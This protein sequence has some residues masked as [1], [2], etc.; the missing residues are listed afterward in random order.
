M[1]TNEKK[2]PKSDG[3][4]KAGVK[5]Y[6]QMASIKSY[7]SATIISDPQIGT[8]QVSM[9][10][11][12][13]D[14]DRKCKRKM[15]SNLTVQVIQESS[16]QSGLTDFKVIARHLPTDLGD[17]E[18]VSVSPS[19]KVQLTSR[20]VDKKRF[21]EITT[22]GS[23]RTIEVTKKHGDFFADGTFG[24]VSWSADETKFVYVSDRETPDNDSKYVESM[25]L[26]EGFTGKLKPTLVFVD[27]AGDEPKVTPLCLDLQASQA[28]MLPA[29]DKIIFNGIE[30][31][32]LPF[33]ILYCYNRRTAIY[34]VSV[35]GTG[36]ERLSA[37]SGVNGRYPQ[38][39]PDGS[40]FVYLSHKVGGA[41]SACNTLV[42][43]KLKSKESSTLVQLVKAVCK[44]TE[45]PGLF[46]DHLIERPWVNIASGLFAILQTSWRCQETLVAVNAST[47]QVHR[48]T[49]LLP[50][51][52]YS[53]V[54]RS[55]TIDGWILATRSLANEPHKLVLGKFE[56]PGKTIN[57]TIIDEPDLPTDVSEG[58]KNI[59][60]TVSTVPGCGPNVQVLM[61]MP[62]KARHPQ[63][64]DTDGG[65]PLVVMPHGGPHGVISTGYSLY[66]SLLVSFGFAV[67]Q[68]NYS[69]STG[70]GDDFVQDVVGRIG[71][72]DLADVN[73]AAYWAS[74]LPGI[75][76]KK[77]SLFGG[78]HG[79]FITAHLLG[80]E[81]DFYKAGVLRNP[82]IN[83]GAMVATT[84]ISDWCF[85]EAGLAFDQSKPHLVTPQEYEFMFRHSPASVVHKIKSPVLLML[86]AGDRRVPP[87][88][89][90]RWSQ[91]LRGAGKDISV[92]MFPSVGHALDSFEAER[93]GFDAYWSF[94][95]KH[96]GQPAKP[97]DA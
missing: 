92:I 62:T 49:S 18:I 37:E 73:A 42:L 66:L 39:T 76:K 35:D 40:A 17:T 83:I 13:R 26:G 47:G 21:L 60:L 97:I 61:L 38:L 82:V 28:I 10:T 19:G 52:Y 70:Y 48:I 95:L 81:P 56:E 69:G 25:D 24:R 85:A 57:W 1:S 20:T 34:S 87:S 51:S 89:G 71:E 72:L 12:Y 79:G 54:L 58:L 11:S 94:L 6:Q 30:D 68:V 14:F 86:G 50:E 53:Y 84:D 27:L 22:L 8:L 75:N 93:Y 74:T 32:P 91:Y 78:S 96:F 46:V 7:A 80:F 77:V 15:L 63:L 55:V 33:G 65:A 67:A 23:F 45:F 16:V 59:N 29:G 44:P 41:H 88:E 36:L 3:K 5:L 9:I 4:D 31:S 2:D 90:L 64:Q 43:H